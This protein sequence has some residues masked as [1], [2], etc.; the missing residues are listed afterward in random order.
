MNLD[1]DNQRFQKH[2]EFARA[3]LAQE[4][5]E[6]Y[7]QILQLLQQGQ[8][9]EAHEMLKTHSLG[10]I[11]GLFEGFTC[12]MLGNY[13]AAKK[14]FNQYSASEYVIP[15]YL[16]L[17]YAQESKFSSAIKHLETAMKEPILKDVCKQPLLGVY[18]QQAMKYTEAGEPGKAKRLWNKVARL[19]PRGC[20]SRQCSVSST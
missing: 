1:P 4:T 2:L 13:A 8:Y 7:T 20:S 19:D 5:H 11:H 6:P 16:G 10:K 17:I 14:A 15:Y 9:A 12:A 3:E 18:K